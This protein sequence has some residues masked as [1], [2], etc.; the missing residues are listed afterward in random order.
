M[1]TGDPDLR[2]LAVETLEE[3]AAKSP[4][5]TKVNEAFK[6]FQKQWGAWSDVSSRSYFDVIADGRSAAVALAGGASS[7]EE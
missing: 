6:K 7:F 2:K 3:E 4:Q 1:I 5:A